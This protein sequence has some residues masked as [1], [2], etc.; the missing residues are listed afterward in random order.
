MGRPLQGAQSGRFYF[1][2]LGTGAKR[3]GG[4][5]SIAGLLL[6]LGQRAISSLASRV[7]L[8]T[9]P[10]GPGLSPQTGPSLLR[11]KNFVVK[12]WSGCP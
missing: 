6:R 11:S 12:A 2:A 3:T 1:E 9:H 10:T 8:D 7:V 5:T 4:D